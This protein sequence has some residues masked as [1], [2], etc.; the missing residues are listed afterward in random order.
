M[1]DQAEQEGVFRLADR[2]S[3]RLNFSHLYTALSRAPYMRFLGLGSS[4]A[5]FEPAARPVPRERLGELREVLQWLYGSRENDIDP[6][7]QL[8]NP[9]VKE[10]GEVLDS[11]EGLEALRATGSLSDA[12]ASAGS[13]ERK[14]RDA[15]VK[16]RSEIRIASN[17]LRGFDGRTN[18]LMGIAEDVSET[19]QSVVGWMRNKMKARPSDPE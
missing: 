12:F 9:H 18:G 19:A 1:L 6:V 2:A 13:A 7:V 5:R 17:N 8:Q 4:W 10:L 11:A 15:L 16:A 14:F 3:P